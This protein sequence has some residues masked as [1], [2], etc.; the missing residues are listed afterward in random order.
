MIVKL[1]NKG[2]KGGE[3]KGKRLEEI[4]EVGDN[5]KGPREENNDE[6]KDVEGG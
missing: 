3:E 4:R 6:N 5:K 2:G 1:R